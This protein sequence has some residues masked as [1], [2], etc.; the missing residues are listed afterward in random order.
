MT[1]FGPGVCD[2]FAALE[3]NNR[4]DWYEANR[5]FWEDRI[6]D[7]MTTLLTAAAAERGGTVKVFRLN[8]DVRFSKDKSPYKTSTA[9]YIS[10][11]TGAAAIYLSMG[12]D[13]LYAG[14]GYYD[15]A[16]DQ[17]DRF[18]TAIAGDAGAA[19]ADIVA[20]LRAHEVEVRGRAVKTAPRGVPKDHE[21]IAL[22]RMKEIV[23]GARLPVDRTESGGAVAHATRIWDL[24]ADLRQWLDAH[25]GPC[26]MA[27]ED[28]F[29]RR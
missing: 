1:A 3:A 16:K 13:G 14:S 23:A 19:L 28:G 26:R 17:L 29:F 6:R 20:S 21:R 12:K 7:P 15:M 8:R 10:P 27:P 9:G 22:L 18:R 25:V 4:R 11:D 5:A 2:W 24:T